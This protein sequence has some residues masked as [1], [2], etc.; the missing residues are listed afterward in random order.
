MVKRGQENK[1]SVQE[2][3]HDLQDEMLSKYN[4][5]KK[6]I[7]HP[8]AKGGTTE[9]NWVEWLGTYLPKRYTVDKG[10]VVDHEGSISQEIDVI[11]YDTQFCPFI[12]N[13]DGVKYIP[14]ESVFAVFEVKPELS[15]KYVKYAGE[16]IKSVRNLRRTTK[17]IVGTERNL[18]AKVLKNIIGGFLVASSS[19]SIKTE[20]YKLISSLLTDVNSRLD[21]V[22]SLQTKSYKL[23]YLSDKITVSS[24]TE[25]ESLIFFFVN[26]FVKL[27]E[28]GNPPA[29]DIMAYAKAM[30]SIK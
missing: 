18:G 2:L 20:E 24:S 7:Q 27:Q 29:M 16:K 9:L 12:F 26:L 4:T 23:D 21:L 8:G 15:A 11:I 25:K 14:A 1:I 5:N 10:F 3:F 6:A 30:D 19:W 28:M 13:H 17:P 22:C